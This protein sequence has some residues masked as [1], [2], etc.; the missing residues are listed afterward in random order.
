L[1]AIV[2]FG[3]HVALW[4]IRRRGD[5]VMASIRVLSFFPVPVGSEVT[6]IFPLITLPVRRCPLGLLLCSGT[7]IVSCGYEVWYLAVHSSPLRRDM[8][9]GEA[10]V[11]PAIA[12]RILSRI[13]ASLKRKEDR[14]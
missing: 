14:T 7:A 11:L 2:D 8:M 1:V 4:K 6:M 9:A 10:M 3:E 12:R 13:F 5:V